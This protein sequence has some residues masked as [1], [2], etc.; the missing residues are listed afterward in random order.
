MAERTGE[1]GRSGDTGGERDLDEIREEL[2]DLQ[3]RLD[4]MLDTGEENAFF[5]PKDREKHSKER[6]ER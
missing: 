2:D 5:P 1:D 4:D 6:D 3:D